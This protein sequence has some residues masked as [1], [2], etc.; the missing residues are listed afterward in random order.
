MKKRYLLAVSVAT[1]VCACL[2]ACGNSSEIEETQQAAE[3]AGD[4]EAVTIVS[5]NINNNL[6]KE[7]EQ[8]DKIHQII[9]DETGV[10]LQL[11]MIPSDQ[12]ATQANL[13]LAGKEQLDIIPCIGMTDAQNLKNSGAVRM[14]TQEELDQ[15]PYLRDSFPKESWDAVRM[16][17]EYLGIP[18]VG[19]QTIPALVA[20]RNDWVDQLGE[21]MP[22]TLEEYEALLKQFKENDL[23][24]NGQ[25]DT[26]PLIADTV[27]ELEQAFLPFFTQTGAYWYFDEEEQLLKPYEMDEGYPE[28]L[29]TM[30]RWID[31]GYLFD[32]IATTSK[33]DKLSYVA[34]NKVGSTAG[35]WTR[36]LYSGIEVLAQTYPDIRYEFVTPKGSDHAANKYTSSQFAKG[37]TLIT[38]TCEHPEKAL[39][40]LNYQ[41]SPEGQTITTYGIEGENYT[42]DPETGKYQIISD[43]PTDWTT[44]QYYI[45]YN[46]HE[47]FGEWRTDLWP[48][49]TYTYNLMNEMNEELKAMDTVTPP[50]SITPYDVSKYEAQ[51]S[52]NDLATLL[53]EAKGKIFAGTMSVDE[54]PNVM[55]QWKEIGG[56]QLIQDKTTQFLENQNSS[57]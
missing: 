42:V 44:A 39:E 54:W 23:D 18:F 9:M 26:I 28:F 19:A 20:V 10:D 34:Q 32:Q 31:E 47:G 36:F 11:V 4:E 25:D 52:M 17:D 30:R 35:T 46:L 3:N 50:D 7:S 24:G 29:E 48:L 15:Y 37:V 38:S 57:K 8:R 41:C 5:L 43:S 16:G 27:D 14:I 1:V 45:L 51:R 12:L 22:E 49:D 6:D 53:S 33:Q 2:G 21:T 40:Y 56:N 55:E 13:M